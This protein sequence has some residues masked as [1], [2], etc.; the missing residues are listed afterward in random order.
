MSGDTLYST[1]QWIIYPLIVLLVIAASEA[2]ARL[3]RLYRGR[4]DIG[5]ELFGTLSVSSFGLLALMLGFTFAMAMTRYEERREAVLR[6]A[7]AIGTAVLRA[8]VLAEP[9]RSESLRLLGEYARLRLGLVSVV[10]PSW[11]QQIDRS[12]AIQ[13][14]LWGI[15]VAET[16]KDPRSVPFGL[17]MQA[18]NDVID[19]HQIRIQALRNHVPSEVIVMLVLLAMTSIAFTGHDFALGRGGRRLPITCMAVLIGLVITLILDLDRPERGLII[20]SNEPLH[21][22]IVGLPAEAR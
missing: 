15:A 8:Q 18:L 16:T 10:A 14:Q 6:E 13:T 20:D 19:E 17:Y 5:K 22:L 4:E 12:L 11:S 7:N 9:E 3:T 2:G 21:D 1:S